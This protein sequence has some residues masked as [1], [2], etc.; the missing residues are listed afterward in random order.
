MKNG[1][2]LTCRKPRNLLRVFG[3]AEGDRTPDLRIANAALCQTELLPH[4]NE[5][6]IREKRPFVSSIRASLCRVIIKNDKYIDGNHFSER[7]AQFV[8]SESRRFACND[9]T[10]SYLTAFKFMCGDFDDFCEPFYIA[11]PAALRQISA[12]TTTTTDCRT[13][14]AHQRIHVTVGIA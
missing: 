1:K 3:G 10:S 14:L 4:T 6:N 9:S 8:V 2:L 13:R 7:F 11:S 5:K 12:S